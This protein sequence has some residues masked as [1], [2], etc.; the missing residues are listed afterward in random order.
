[1]KPTKENQLCKVDV[2]QTN[3]AVKLYVI[4]GNL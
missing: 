4:S 1:M 2:K 3:I